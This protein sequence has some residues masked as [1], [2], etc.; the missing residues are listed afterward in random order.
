MYETVGFENYKCCRFKETRGLEMAEQ[1]QGEDREGHMDM[2]LSED[3]GGTPRAS[4]G[5]NMNQR[6]K[7]A[8]LE[9]MDGD[10]YVYNIEVRLGVHVVDLLVCWKRKKKLVLLRL[11]ADTSERES[12]DGD[13]MICVGSC[14]ESR[15]EHRKETVEALAEDIDQHQGEDGAEE[16]D[17]SHTEASQVHT[18]G[19]CRKTYRALEYV[20]KSGSHV[21]HSLV[22]HDITT[23]FTDTSY[24]L[25]DNGEGQVSVLMTMNPGYVHMMRSKIK[26]TTLSLTYSEQVALCEATTY[27]KRDKTM[28]LDLSYERGKPR[29]NLIGQQGSHL[30]DGDQ[31]SYVNRKRGRTRRSNAFEGVKKRESV[32]TRTDGVTATLDTRTDVRDAGGLNKDRDREWIL[33][34]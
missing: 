7:C 26:T 30:T 22:E 18:K 32:L 34:I 23:T 28:L 3:M 19:G 10:L 11:G 9:P 20:D 17:A 16:G 29:R 21:V 31:G 12:Q 33:W 5:N 4:Q 14:D 27:A 24:G 6:H 13:Y 15:K 1:S 25:H 2:E 8:S